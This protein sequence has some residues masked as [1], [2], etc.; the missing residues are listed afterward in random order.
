MPKSE[1]PRSARLHL[2]QQRKRAKDLLRALRRSDRNA[3]MRF[4]RHL[5]RAA[6][7]ALGEIRALEPRLSDAQTVVAREAGFGSWA[8]LKHSIE[9]A[10]DGRNAQIEKL[11]EA[12]IAGDDDRAGDILR[13]TPDLPNRSIHVAAAVADAE[14]AIALLEDR[15]ERAL[16]PLGREDWTPLAY[17][18]FARYG[19]DSAHI[20]RARVLIAER[21]I[22][23]GAAPN[24]AVRDA[25]AAEGKRCPLAGAAE[26]P[27]SPELVDL[28]LRK[29]APV[30]DMWLDAVPAAVRG[31]NPAC[32]RRIL[33]AKPFWYNVST[34]LS[35]AVDANEIE[36]ARLLLEH[37]RSLGWEAWGGRAV[38]RALLLGRIAMVEALLSSGAPATH[39]GR[40]GRSLLAM[41]IRTGQSEAASLLRQYGA[42]DADVTDVDRALGAC[43]LGVSAPRDAQRQWVRSDH[44]L[45]SWAIRVGKTHAVP[46]L[47]ALGL[48]PNVPDDEGET[49]LHLA[50][51]ARS[52][53]TVSALLAAGADANTEN[54]DQETPLALAMR[55]PTSELRAGLTESLR[56]AGAIA[57]GAERGSYALFEE[58]ADAVVN[59]DLARLRDLL[60]THPRLAAERS[61]RGH[62]ATLLHYVAANGVENERQ[63]SPSNA[64]R[65]AEL[66]LDRGAIPDALIVGGRHDHTPLALA[67]S[68]VHPEV[69]GVIGDIVSAL[70]RGGA[71]VDGV[72]DDCAPLLSA[73]GQGRIAAIGALVSAG[74]RI[75][76]VVMAAAAGR[77]DLVKEFATAGGSEPTRNEL[78]QALIQAAYRDHAE[79][80]EFLL[81]RGV[82]PA[83]TDGQAFT[84]LHWAAGGGFLDVVRLLVAR[85]APLEVKNI[86][87]GTVLDFTGW[88]AKNDPGGVD[89]VPV[90]ELLL[91]AGAN[92]E[93]AFPS[94]D[95]RVDEVLSRHRATR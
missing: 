59:G 25:R 18:C 69:A 66:L 38:E 87:G 32:L 77:L 48:D 56:R 34:G 44:L 11:L 46:A 83:A 72:D 12:A 50:L 43:W 75:G 27:A 41:A 65:I 24:E 3:A 9:V 74:A 19:R 30:N 91:A 55:E 49:P 95:P 60:D 73:I 39:R 79:V 57:A 88:A 81:E 13:G 84:A 23:L 31:G 78:E 5:P 70:V 82:D 51:R 52:L 40:D 37:G 47:L 1:R 76:S 6:G 35:A 61:R 86:Y 14:T 15:P 16:E 63:R 54:F 20:R 64:A 85:G 62:K 80:V 8:R 7:L 92:V 93:A 94:G 68:S 22:E 17:V 90:V 67:V 26:A 4:A 45:L 21:L 58:A 89:R 28:L 33:A 71:K 42:S 29:G 53:E 10:S 36:A 2:E